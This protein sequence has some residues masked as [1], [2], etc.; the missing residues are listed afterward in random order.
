MVGRSDLD[1]GVDGIGNTDGSRR[2]G[3]ESG[4]CGDGNGWDGDVS[5]GADV[6]CGV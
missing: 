4:W 3:D 2:R 1:D 6:W 5:G